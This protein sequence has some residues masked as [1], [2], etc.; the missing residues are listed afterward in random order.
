[1]EEL[2]RIA[3]PDAPLAVLI[4]GFPLAVFLACL[5]P[6][7]ARMQ[8]NGRA[9]R[10]LCLAA[11]AMSVWLV[12]PIRPTDLTGAQLRAM[13][14]FLGWVGLLWQWGNWVWDSRPAPLWPHLGAGVLALACGLAVGFGL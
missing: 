10:D 9:A 5:G 1:M 7:R 8:A 6:A 14:S 4:L 2:G 12:L 11:L 13:V 3:A